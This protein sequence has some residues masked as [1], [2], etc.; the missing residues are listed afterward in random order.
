MGYNCDRKVYVGAVRP[1]SATL[2]TFSALT[3]PLGGDVT[4]VS[5]TQNGSHVMITW[6]TQEPE[7]GTSAYYVRSI[8]YSQFHGAYPASFATID[9]SP[10]VRRSRPTLREAA[11]AT[12]SVGGD[13]VASVSMEELFD[14]SPLTLSANGTSRVVSR[15]IVSALINAGGASEGA[16][17]VTCTSASFV[18]S[19]TVGPAIS[20]NCTAAK[21]YSS[22]Q[23]AVR[24]GE[25]PYTET[26]LIG[27]LSVA[28]ILP[29]SFKVE[30]PI[31]TDGIVGPAVA[32]IPS[33]G[34]DAIKD[35]H[36]SLASVAPQLS[37]DASS[38]T[39]VGAVAPVQ[40]DVA[41]LNRGLKSGTVVVR[42]YND[43]AGGAFVGEYVSDASSRLR[44]GSRRLASMVLW[45]LKGPG[46]FPIRVALFDSPTS[47]LPIAQSTIVVSL[48]PTSPLV[49]PPSAIAAV[50]ANGFVPVSIPAG[51]FPSQTFYLFSHQQNKI[52]SQL[53]VVDFSADQTVLLDAT[54]LASPASSPLSVVFAVSQLTA[55]MSQLLSRARWLPVPYSTVVPFMSSANSTVLVLG[56]PLSMLVNSSSIN[57]VSLL[58]F[59]I[60]LPALSAPWGVV[61]SASATNGAS[62][63]FT[64]SSTD[65]V[66]A[67]VPSSG[68]RSIPTGPSSAVLYFPFSEITPSQLFVTVSVSQVN[69]STTVS[70]SA[71][72]AQFFQPTAAQKSV[73]LD[74]SAP[75]FF[76]FRPS[77]R[78]D[79][80]MSVNREFSNARL[81]Y[82]TRN[83]VLGANQGATEAASSVLRY[84]T[85]L[86]IQGS[87]NNSVEV[88][89]NIETSF[90]VSM[91]PPSAYFVSLMPNSPAGG[92]VTL[93]LYSG[94]VG[95]TQTS[96]C[97]IDP[98]S[99]ATVPSLNLVYDEGSPFVSEI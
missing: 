89:Q 32:V 79:L 43:A 54:S 93:Y 47:T 88:Q 39:Q 16:G 29:G 13:A 86:L 5:Y 95:L 42:A 92:L 45:G 10:V 49:L 56:N 11:L 64:A 65:F 96:K 97:P 59:I 70:V 22:L 73:A 26:K 9:A 78:G 83:Y 44:F 25:L 33:S 77:F 53:S 84:K 30:V 67:S 71:Q 66:P 20:V 24:S 58:K 48:A 62:V 6:F 52:I 41:V 37:F 4:S 90:A 27:Q 7:T 15:R 46:E 91:V 23:F 57:D 98:L 50:N 69:P 51:N 31:E 85:N 28:N 35:F 19:N 87:S 94:F 12:F 80:R 68:P 2:P 14:A 38:L 40:L 34:V 61:I 75:A 18:V 82:S 17:S 63:S 72:L 36:F 81:F 60:P 1:T 74:L 21:A 76:I 8:R 55:D 3:A 99:S